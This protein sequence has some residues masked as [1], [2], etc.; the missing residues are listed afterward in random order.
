[1]IDLGQEAPRD[2]QRF[3]EVVAAARRER[4]ALGALGGRVAAPAAWLERESARFE[5]WSQSLLVSMERWDSV[6]AMDIAESVQ[7]FQDGQHDLRNGFHPRMLSRLDVVVPFVLE[8]RGIRGGYADVVELLPPLAG[9]LS[10]AGVEGFIRGEIAR[11]QAVASDPVLLVQHQEAELDET[12]AHRAGEQWLIVQH[13][14]SGLRVRFEHHP[15]R[16]DREGVVYAKPYKMP[17]IDPDRPEEEGRY[18]VDWRDY[19]GLGIG[20]RLYLKAAE[21]LPDVRWGSGSVGQYAQPVRTKLHRADPWRW[22]SRTCT[23]RGSWSA[24]TRQ[25]AART[26]HEPLGAD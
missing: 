12:E 23:C 11:R 25:A 2:G 13:R 19:A 20:T 1:M 22:W 5:R 3:A 8:R 6:A 4:R 9:R 14:A 16:P 26:V 24:L 17:S 10:S 18:A 7:K 21:L 15:G